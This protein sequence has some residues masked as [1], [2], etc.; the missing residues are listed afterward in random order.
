MKHLRLDVQFGVLSCIVLLPCAPRNV[1]AQDKTE[2]GK[3]VFDTYSTVVGMVYPVAGAMFK[4]AGEMLD[5]FGYFGNTVDPVGEAIKRINERLDILEKR[6]SGLET[7]VQAIENELFRKENLD[8]VR[9]LRSKQDALKLLAYKLQQKPTEKRDKLALAKEAEIIVSRFLDDP[10]LWNWSDM[11]GRDGA[12]LPPDFKPLPALEYYVVALVTWVAA[13]EYAADGDYEFVKRTYGPEL[14][15][16]I[17]YLSVRPGWKE[18]NGDAETLPENIMARVSCSLELL[19]SSPNAITRKC[20]IHEGC[21]D[22]IARV[23]STV[24]IHEEIMPLGTEI[25]NV[26]YSARKMASQDELERMYGTEE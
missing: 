2:D 15:K 5:T 1:R 20:T 13:I 6:V 14:R 26:P 10:D 4:A 25:C 17:A 23:L 11:R 9:L 24:A 19:H 7:K 8:R 21:K 3:K 18:S 22:Q 12:M 16:H